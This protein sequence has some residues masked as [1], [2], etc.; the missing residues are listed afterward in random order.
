MKKK[1]VSDDGKGK[2]ACGHI[3]VFTASARRPDALAD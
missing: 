1:E 3:D 2:A